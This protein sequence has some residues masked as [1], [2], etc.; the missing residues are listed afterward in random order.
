MEINPLQ[1]IHNSYR[2]VLLLGGTLVSAAGGRCTILPALART[3]LLAQ[4]LG[5][6][7]GTVQR[8][9][10]GFFELSAAR[11]IYQTCCWMS[12]IW[13]L[14]KGNGAALITLCPTV[15]SIE[16]WIQTKNCLKASYFI[17]AVSPDH[18]ERL[19]KEKNHH[20][21]QSPQTS[22]VHQVS[23]MLSDQADSVTASTATRL[24]LQLVA[25]VI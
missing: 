12:C 15:K 4:S 16:R 1:E 6:F 13:E 11:R 23:S 9:S 14:V 7:A 25:N 8:C 20:V 22:S 21:R 18:K 19:V 5:I 17:S 24:G 3:A 2:C 10:P